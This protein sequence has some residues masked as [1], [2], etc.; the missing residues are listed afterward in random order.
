[1]KICAI[2]GKAINHR[3]HRTTQMWTPVQRICAKPFEYRS[4]KNLFISLMGKI[5]F[6]N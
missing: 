1:M 5:D 2:F 3:F 6:P 4:M